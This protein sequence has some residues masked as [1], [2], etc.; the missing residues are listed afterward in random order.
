MQWLS[1]AKT[2]LAV[3][4]HHPTYINSVQQN[5]DFNMI[6]VFSWQLEPVV[7]PGPAHVFSQ[8]LYLI[9]CLFLWFLPNKRPELNYSSGRGKS[10]LN[11]ITRPYLLYAFFDF[12]RREGGRLSSSL[13]NDFSDL[14]F[15]LSWK[16][17][18]G[19]LTAA[20]SHR[21]GHW[22]PISTSCVAL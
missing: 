9:D 22:I 10:L 3:I 2:E 17:D 7:S 18:R 1:N 4:L 11:W 8:A 15:F 19:H 12:E 16:S 20:K 5:Y 21:G 13:C 14:F 6:E